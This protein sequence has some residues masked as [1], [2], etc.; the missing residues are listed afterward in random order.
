MRDYN[1]QRPMPIQE[2][3]NPDNQI[4]ML[5]FTFNIKIWK[6]KIA[7]ITLTIF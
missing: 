2:G 1:G 7:T 3:P 4:F 6:L 5:Q